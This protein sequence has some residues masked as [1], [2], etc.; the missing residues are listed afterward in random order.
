MSVCHLDENSQNFGAYEYIFE[1]EYDNEK[2]KEYLSEEKNQQALDLFYPRR[3]E[4]YSDKEDVE[5]FEQILASLATEKIGEAGLGGYLAEPLSEDYVNDWL[6]KMGIVCKIDYDDWD[7]INQLEF[8][9]DSKYDFNMKCGNVE[10]LVKNCESVFESVSDMKDFIVYE[11]KTRDAIGEIL[12][13]HNITSPMFDDA[14]RLNYEFRCDLPGEEGVW[15]N[16]KKMKGEPKD[17]EDFDMSGFIDGFLVSYWD[18]DEMLQVPIM[19]EKIW[20]SDHVDQSACGAELNYWEAESF[21]TYL[22]GQSSF[23][24]TW[25]CMINDMDFEEVYGK[26]YNKLKK[27]W[28]QSLRASLSLREEE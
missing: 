5:M 23:E 12:K 7:D 9:K 1:I 16:Y 21:V 19:T 10:Y 4:K 14:F 3:S 18:G 25:N 24:T 15:A 27:E 28:M 8:R 20:Q 13:D 11:M 6:A 17:I 22:I 2:I 26:T